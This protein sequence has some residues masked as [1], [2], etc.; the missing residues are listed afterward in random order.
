[1]DEWESVLSPAL[2]RHASSLD[3]R[4][5]A[6]CATGPYVSAPRPWYPN[7][8][9]LLLQHRIVAPRHPPAETCKCGMPQLQRESLGTSRWAEGGI[10]GDGTLAQVLP[11]WQPLADHLGSQI[12]STDRSGPAQ[13]PPLRTVACSQH[14][15]SDSEIPDGQFRVDFN[16]S[17]ALLLVG[18]GGGG[19]GDPGCRPWRSERDRLLLRASLRN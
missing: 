3:A 5:A 1:M 14:R 18:G 17:Y 6:E 4:V 8:R 16:A 2:M 15:V 12:L 10:P 11:D 13:T 19:G 9:D 7:F